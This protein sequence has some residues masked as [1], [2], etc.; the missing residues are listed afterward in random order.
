MTYGMRCVWRTTLLVVMLSNM[1]FGAKAQRDTFVPECAGESLAPIER[2]CDSNSNN[3]NRDA[4][5]ALLNELNALECFCNKNIGEVAF[6][7]RQRVIPVTISAADRLC[8]IAIKIG[9]ECTPIPRFTIEPVPSPPLSLSSPPP[10]L[11]P[12]SAPPSSPPTA[13][14]SPAYMSAPVKSTCD[15]DG[16]ISLIQ[17]GCSAMGDESSV[18]SSRIAPQCCDALDKLNER[19]CFCEKDLRVREI[20]NEFPANW[21]KMF[22]DAPKVCS[23]LVIRGGWQCSPYIARSPPPPPPP[24]PSVSQPTGGGYGYIRRPTELDIQ[25][26]KERV[27]TVSAFASILDAGCASLPYLDPSTSKAQ[28]CCELVGL[29]NSALCFCSSI[30]TPLIDSSR[31]AINPMFAATAHVCDF[32]TFAYDGCVFVDEPLPTMP[33]PPSPPPAP[34]S[35]PTPSSWSWWPFG[36]RQQH[37][38]NPAPAQTPLWPRRPELPPALIDG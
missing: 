1:A 8:G 11:T 21:H 17:A 34:T 13:I 38:A 24:P 15:V 36:A 22:S 18:L 32:P 31:A 27:C 5:C 30:L 16:L 2:L 26:A 3:F 12:P 37:P 9:N 19:L 28:R 29:M 7:V 14:R 25:R 10:P 6:E 35:T 23:G 33:P 20:L 4:C